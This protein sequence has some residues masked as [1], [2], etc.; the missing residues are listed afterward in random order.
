MRPIQVTIPHTNIRETGLW[1]SEILTNASIVSIPAGTYGGNHHHPR[2][3]IFAC[4]SGTA[5]LIWEE[6]GRQNKLTMITDHQNELIAYQIPPHL[7]HAVK[8]SG[9]QSVILLEYSTEPQHDVEKV[10]LV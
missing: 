6:D 10:N 7:P 5:T 4:L 2:I 3:E 1:S 8:N 9:D